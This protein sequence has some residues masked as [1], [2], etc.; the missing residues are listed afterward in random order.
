VHDQAGGAAGLG[1]DGADRQ[2]LDPLERQDAPDGFG[3]PL[4]LGLRIG[5]ACDGGPPLPRLRNICYGNTCSD[6]PAPG[7]TERKSI[8][9][10]TT[11]WRIEPRAWDDPEGVALR[12][13]QRAELDARF[14]RDDHEP[15]PVPS[16]SDMEVFLVAVGEDGAAVAC[17]G[18]RELEPGT[19]EVKRMFVR[20]ETR[21]SG[22][23]PA[24]LAALEATAR[25]HGWHRLRLETG[26]EARMPDA[27]RFYA[28]E[29]YLRIPRYGHYVDSDIS[30]CYEKRLD[31]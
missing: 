8:M 25:E 26:D 10:T 30:I 1:G 16:A 9:R 3:D 13:G 12:V 6:K 28:R 29:G 22:V 20:P 23:A 7:P 4:L 19:A 5:A 2:V 11:G 18:L 31:R 15:G 27:N 17:G 24:L 21:G 14:G